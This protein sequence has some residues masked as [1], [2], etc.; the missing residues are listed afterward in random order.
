MEGNFALF[1]SYTLGL[2]NDFQ[3]ILLIVMVSV[4][5]SPTVFVFGLVGVCVCVCGG[6]PSKY[7]DLLFNPWVEEC[8]PASFPG[9]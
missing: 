3:N 8:F 2:H 9:K 5:D 4:S 1:L 6:A 7:K